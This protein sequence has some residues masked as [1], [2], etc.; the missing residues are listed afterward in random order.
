MR[1][2]S[3]LFMQVNL[4]TL[5]V[6]GFA[7]LL[8]VL[9]K[10]GY[11]TMRSF[12][13]PEI[14][15][16][17]M[18]LADGTAVVERVCSV[19]GQSIIPPSEQYCDWQGNRLS[20]PNDARWVTGVPLYQG[21]TGHGLFEDWLTP[22]ESWE[23][24]L[25]RFPDAQES[26]AWYF[27]CDG[28]RHGKA[29]FVAYDLRE[30]Q[31]VGYIGTAGFRAEELPP[32]E[33]FPF[34]GS[35]RGIEYRL[36]IPVRTYGSFLPIN[37][38]VNHGPRF[39]TRKIYVRGD[40][41]TIYQVDLNARNV[42]VAF[43]GSPIYAAGLLTR[44]ESPSSAGRSFLVVRT[45]DA[46]LEFDGQNKLVR[47]FS[48]P[49]DLRKRGFSWFETPSGE[50]ITLAD[51]EWEF[52]T[53]QVLL[54]VSWYDSAGQLL[55]QDQAWFRRQFPTDERFFMA[56]TLTPAIANWVGL[57]PLNIRYVENWSEYRRELSNRLKVLWPALVF[58]HFAAAALAVLAYRRLVRYATSRTE[59]IVWPLFV[60]VFGLPGWIGFRFV[61]KWPMLEPCP[62]CAAI[63]PRDRIPCA[64]CAADFPLPVL[65]GTEVFA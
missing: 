21:W 52:S 3:D 39:P 32:E 19:N 34:N 6:I 40:N 59:R 56:F 58:V 20:V 26:V 48:I 54:Q 55:R 50:I 5:L 43:T 25:R 44:Y 62:T 11:E 57:D 35:D 4:A 18:F 38:G 31:R 53:S 13:P 49:K 42:H 14:D 17:P 24:R 16:R 37:S 63:V 36:M 9:A 64:R 30:S 61:R 8:G 27:I 28:K 46:V 51:L 33:Y 47:R 7:A 12:R 41:D 23:W 22:D 1:K 15:E 29:Y 10:W 65:K 2:A 60:V 45:E